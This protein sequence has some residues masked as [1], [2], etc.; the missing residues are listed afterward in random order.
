MTTSDVIA[1]KATTAA[2]VGLTV[3]GLTVTEWAAVVAIIVGLLQCVI[4]LPK[5]IESFKQ[6][7]QSKR[8]SSKPVPP[9][10]S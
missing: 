1:G 6:W 2:T 5:A 3:L 10:Q 7:R 4:L 8:D 9:P